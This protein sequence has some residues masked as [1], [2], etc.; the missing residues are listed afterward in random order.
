MNKIYSSIDDWYTPE[1][2]FYEMLDKLR[3]TRTYMS[4][5]LQKSAKDDDYDFP[6]KSI[7]MMEHAGMYDSGHKPGHNQ[8]FQFYNLQFNNMLEAMICS[9]KPKTILEVGAGSG[10]LTSILNAR[11]LQVIATDDYSW[12]FKKRYCKVEK[13]DVLAAIKKYNPDLII[14]C[15]APLYTDCT[16]YFRVKPHVKHYITIGEING[17]CG[18]NWD[19]RPGWTMESTNAFSL[20]RTDS[21]WFDSKFPNLP[22]VFPFTHSSV[23]C[24]SRK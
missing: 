15:W 1:I 4:D 20:C 7:M 18:G 17:C 8:K 19:K 9:L 3:W 6:L 10:L 12:P 22:P 5:A 2:D 14:A 16:P 13:L 24:F 23:C 11:G 21:L